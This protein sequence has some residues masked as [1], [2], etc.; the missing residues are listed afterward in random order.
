LERFWHKAAENFER[1]VKIKVQFQ[2]AMKL[3][4]GKVLFVYMLFVYFSK[5]NTSRL[6][7][8]AYGKYGIF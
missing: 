6:S 4:I 8:K 2:K 5:R 7:A 3:N 1:K